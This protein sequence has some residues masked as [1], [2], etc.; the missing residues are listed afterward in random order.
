MGKEREEEER[1]GRRDGHGK[2]LE[3]GERERGKKKQER[4][5]GKLRGMR[6][7]KDGGDEHE[8]WEEM[9]D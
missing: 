7:E 5:E 6:T 9:R 8:R 2:G 4:N 3:R 1:E